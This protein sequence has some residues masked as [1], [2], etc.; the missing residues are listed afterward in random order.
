MAGPDHRIRA[1]DDFPLILAGAAIALHYGWTLAPAE[2]QAQVWN[3]SGAIARAILLWVA[4]AHFR[5]TRTLAAVALWWLAEETMVATCS[6]V[7][8]FAPWP[9]PPGAAQ[10]SALLQFD[11]GKV[12]AA[13][14]VA[15]LATFPHRRQ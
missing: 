1:R 13:T 10:C 14:L 11:L 15:I 5:M 9:V 8:I 12:G 3:A 2:H 7:F 4:L 6:A